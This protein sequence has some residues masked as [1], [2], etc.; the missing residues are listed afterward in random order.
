MAGCY[1]YGIVCLVALYSLPMSYCIYTKP[2]LFLGVLLAMNAT[3]KLVVS[4]PRFGRYPNVLPIQPFQSSPNMYS[5]LTWTTTVWG[6]RL[7][8]QDEHLLASQLRSQL[9]SLSSFLYCATLQGI[10]YVLPWLSELEQS[11]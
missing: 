11:L 1:S 2:K 6:D 10:R 7:C 8:G 3:G 5:Y 4:K 9:R